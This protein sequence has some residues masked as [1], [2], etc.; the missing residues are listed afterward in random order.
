MY[1]AVNHQFNR[2]VNRTILYYDDD[3]GLVVVDGCFDE[4]MMKRRCEVLM[5]LCEGWTFECADSL[6]A[7]LKVFH[8][9][10]PRILRLQLDEQSCAHWMF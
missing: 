1:R 9:K 3:G 2:R 8:G 4:I 10:M 6:H 5:D 7:L